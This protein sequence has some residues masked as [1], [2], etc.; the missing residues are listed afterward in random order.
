MVF[1]GM[2]GSVS[3][4]S[5]IAIDLMSLAMNKKGFIDDEYIIFRSAWGEYYLVYGELVLED[6]YVV[7]EDVTYIRY[8]LANETQGIYQYENGSFDSFS[9]YLNEGAYPTS[10]LENVGYAS[11]S[12]VEYKY[13]LTQTDVAYSDNLYMFPLL[14]ISVLLALIF[15]RLGGKE[16]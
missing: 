10:S 7:G 6:D 3:S 2:Y 1:S 14:L 15:I 9:L 4:N 12:S 5:D 13:Y 11:L 8:Y 16:E